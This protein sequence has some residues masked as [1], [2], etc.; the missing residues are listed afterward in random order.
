[1]G[2][3]SVSSLLLGLLC[4]LSG[5]LLPGDAQ[6]ET[7]PLPSDSRG[8]T[9]R[10]LPLPSDS[11]GVT[12]RPLPLPSDSRGVTTR[13]LPLPSDSP[14]VT[15]RPLFVSSADLPDLSVRSSV[16]EPPDA[17][18]EPPGN[19]MITE[20]PSPPLSST[21]SVPDSHDAGSHVTATPGNVTGASDETASDRSR[22]FPPTDSNGAT[23]AETTQPL[24]PTQEPSAANDVTVDTAREISSL[25]ATL[26]TTAAAKT[27]PSDD[28]TPLSTTSMSFH[29]TWMTAITTSLFITTTVTAAEPSRP[30]TQSTAAP[31][32]TRAEVQRGP[33][34][35]EVG[36]EKDLTSYHPRNSSN[37]LFVMIVSVFTI[38]VVMVVV[39]VGFHRYKKR[40]SRTEFRRL[41]DLPMDD[42]MEDTPLSLYS[43]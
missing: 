8:V 7:S 24:P 15:T 37:P 22:I 4:L 31:H 33:S 29:S 14:G 36:D 27:Q 6:E 18:P 10:P 17:S 3:R 9:T 30:R 1:M 35:L 25:V 12:T 11:R 19:E 13:P 41:Q 34:V 2:G 5:A 42:M 26:R 38:M 28:S 43:Y 32:T 23:S 40:N 39:V 20:Q 16:S 21:L